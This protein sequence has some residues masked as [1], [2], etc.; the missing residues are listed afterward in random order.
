MSVWNV[1]IHEALSYLAE[2]SLVQFVPS[3]VYPG[4]HEQLYPPSVLIHVAL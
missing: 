4:L 2:Y 1:L 3:M